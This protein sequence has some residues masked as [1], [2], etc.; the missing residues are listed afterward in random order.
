MT[1]TRALIAEFKKAI[2][3]MSPELCSLSSRYLLSRIC[4]S[5]YVYSRVYF[6]FL[7]VYSHVYF[8]HSQYF[9]CTHVRTG[10]NRD[11]K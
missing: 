4:G 11:R 8:T 10:N 2:L 7:H 3:I 5:T 1:Q 6:S 9:Y